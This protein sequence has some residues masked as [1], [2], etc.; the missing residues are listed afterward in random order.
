MLVD[1]VVI[2]ASDFSSHKDSP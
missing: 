2:N 1:I